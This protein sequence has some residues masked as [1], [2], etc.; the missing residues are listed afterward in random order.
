[1]TKAQ[2]RPT[3]RNP[4]ASLPRRREEEIAWPA[5]DGPSRHVCTQGGRDDRGRQHDDDDRRGH[6]HRRLDRRPRP[7]LP[8]ADG[9][10]TLPE[11]ICAAN[12][13]PGEDTIALQDSVYSIA[14]PHNFWYSPTAP[15]RR[16]RV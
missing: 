1:M 12:G 4:D 9:L 15:C 14:G 6:L 8:G 3:T 10:T 16:F 5:P 7:D 2:D 13:T 11:A